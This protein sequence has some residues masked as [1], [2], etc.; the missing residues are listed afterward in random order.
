MGINRY[1]AFI[2]YRHTELDKF[3]AINLHRKLEAFKL[4][5]GVKSPTGKTKIT[6][7][8]RDEDELPLSSNLSEPIN[9]AL[10]NSDFLLVICT[11]RLQ[12]SEWCKHEIKTFIKLHGRDKILAVLAEGEP[13]ESFPKELCEEEYEVTNPD[14]SIEKKIRVIEP[15]AA[16]VRGKSKHEIKKALDDAVL[17]ISAKIFDLNYDDLKQR[18][19]ERQFKRTLSVVSTVAASL[20]LFSAVCVGLM[21]KIINQSEMIMEQNNEIVAQNNEIKA[22]AAEIEQKNA[23]IKEQFKETQLG[24]AVATASNAKSILSK[25]RRLDA[26][27]ALRQV[28][29]DSMDNDEVPYTPEVQ[30]ELTDALELYYDHTFA[31]SDCIFESESNIVSTKISEDESKILSVDTNNN[32][33]VWD[34][35]MQQELYTAKT[36]RLSFSNDDCA[37]FVNNST[38]LY[39]TNEGL[40]TYDFNSKECKP[41]SYIETGVFQSVRVFPFYGNSKFLISSGTKYYLFDKNDFNNS[42]C[43]NDFADLVEA[44]RVEYANLIE[45]ESHL[46]LSLFKN[47]TTYIY[48]IDLQTGNTITIDKIST[49]PDLDDYISVEDYCI[50]KDKLYISIFESTG[51]FTASYYL[52]AYD[53]T[54]NKQIWSTETSKCVYNIK[55]TGDQS[56][57]CCSSKEYFYCFDASNGK[58]VSSINEGSEIVYVFTFENDMAGFITADYK[59]YNFRASIGYVKQKLLNHCPNE[60]PEEIYVTNSGIILYLPN[61]NYLNYYSYN[62]EQP[63]IV[64]ENFSSCDAVSAS[65]NYFACRT[66]ESV[67]VKKSDTTEE[68]FSFERNP[69]YKSVSF[70]GDGQRYIMSYESGCEVYDFID[71]S[72]VYGIES[73]ESIRDYHISNDKNYFLAFN[74]S[75]KE[76]SVRIMATGDKFAVIDNEDIV[77]YDRCHLINKDYIL[78]CTAGEP[79]KLYSIKENKVVFETERNFAQEYK[80]IPILQTSYFGI[81]YS[82]GIIEIYN[83]ADTVELVGTIYDEDVS[84]Y[85]Y[86]EYFESKGIYVFTDGEIETKVYNSNLETIARLDFPAYYISSKNI[87][88]KIS[89]ECF[90]VPFYSYEEVLKKADEVLGDYE[91]S[92]RIKKMY[93]IKD[94]KN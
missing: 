76:L 73:L 84:L 87:F 77:N 62:Y 43:L 50:G 46:I 53:L 72:K 78:Y 40:Q 67:I 68:I 22:Q 34:I 28:A 35:V 8:F 44:D 66:K 69:S 82:D 32:L 60:S 81:V 18:H 49:P 91:P 19:K 16:D 70:V 33:H 37:F 7:V 83:A 21:F 9:L 42:I 93:N 25:G 58:S 31:F 29:P 36:T 54:T 15:L 20:L 38:I 5:H 2:S 39:N 3:V 85:K 13:A 17:R 65:G 26:L 90:N 12:E 11:P 59:L 30:Y 74:S 64:G 57:V 94:R 92:E 80:I 24:Y 4:P 51:V 1:D 6:R 14:G 56:Y 61:S 10:E 27:Y 79:C 41:F 75:E 71:G 86:G 55:E 45:D 47:D 88:T 89:D 48:N 23:Q 63:D 52:R